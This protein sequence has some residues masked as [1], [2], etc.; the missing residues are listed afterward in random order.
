MVPGIIGQYIGTGTCDKWD[1]WKNRT[2]ESVLELTEIPGVGAK[3][4]RTLYRDHHID[5][6]KKLKKALDNDEL[7]GVKGVGKKTI[8][9]MRRHIAKGNEG[10]QC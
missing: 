4:A 2:P 10:K 1:E 3:T 7:T 5:G 6:L 9:T 8:E